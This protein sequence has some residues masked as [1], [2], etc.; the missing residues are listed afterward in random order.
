MC[1][2]VNSLHR[3]YELRKM[4]GINKDVKELFLFR[5]EIMMVDLWS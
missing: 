2:L 3:V 1:A 5:T 4:Q